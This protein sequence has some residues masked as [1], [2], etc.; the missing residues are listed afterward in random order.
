MDKTKRKVFVVGRSIGYASWLDYDVTQKLEEADVVLF[1]GG[2]DINPEIYKEEPHPTTS[3]SETRDSFEIKAYNQAREHKKFLLGICRGAQLICALQPN[4]RLI[5][6]QYNPGRHELITNTRQFM[7]NSLHHQA[8]Y[9]FEMNQK[10]YEIIGWTNN[11]N[12]FHYNGKGEEMNPPLE[13]EIVYF[14]K[15][16]ALCIQHHPEMMAYDCEEN[17][18]L[19]TLLE[20]K[21]TEFNK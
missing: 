11:I 21:L 13:C 17:E 16:G 14:N 1:T 18:F 4:G 20:E 6:H 9:P 15:I 7:I 5:Q 8:M 19:R 10:D 3:F 2:E 12:K